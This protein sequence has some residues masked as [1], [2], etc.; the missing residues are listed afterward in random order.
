MSK[1]AIVLGATGLVGGHLIEQ[2]VQHDAYTRVVALSRRPLE[3]E[4]P[5]LQVALLDFDNPDPDKIKGDDLYC[6]LGTTLR[7][8]GSKEAQYRIDCTYPYE[9]GKIARQNG[10]QQYVLVSSIGAST[11]TGN[12]YLRTKGELEQKLTDLDFPGLIIGRPSAILGDRGEFRLGEKIGIFLV[13]VLK[14]FVPKRYRGIQAAQIARALIA[15]AV[16][17]QEGTR[18]IESDQ[19]Q[20]IG[21]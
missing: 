10:V 6:A 9:I 7:K 20:G 21:R 14:P 15:S 3:Y 19:L 5:K 12:F 2:L 8:A 1:T 4:H 18:I 13:Q 16:E 17:G 11:K